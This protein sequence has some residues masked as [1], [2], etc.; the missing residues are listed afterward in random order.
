MLVKQ[1]KH[2]WTR[3]LVTDVITFFKNKVILRRPQVANFTG[4]IKIAFMLIKTT[5]KNSIKIKQ[6]TNYA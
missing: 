1:V 6:T 3:A 5:F 2:K 4:I